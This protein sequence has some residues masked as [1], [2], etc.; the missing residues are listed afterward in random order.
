MTE[1]RKN[2]TKVQDKFVDEYLKDPSDGGEAYMRANGSTNKKSASVQSSKLLKMPKIQEALKDKA[3]S[4]LGVLEA[5][6]MQNVEFWINI[7]DGVLSGEGEGK[8]ISR[9]K[10]FKILEDIG[11]L[12]KSDLYKKLDKLDT[13]FVNSTRLVDR[14]KASENLGKYMQMFVEKK[15]I[16]LTAQVTIVDDI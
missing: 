8:L 4:Y 11:I 7:R 15:E 16:D 14:M 10:V 5:R 6:I 13:I 1:Q 2:L 9:E 12:E 3:K